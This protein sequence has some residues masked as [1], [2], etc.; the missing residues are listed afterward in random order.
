VTPL[1]GLSRGVV[2]YGLPQWRNNSSSSLS[3]VVLTPQSIISRLFYYRYSSH[4][5]IVHY[6]ETEFLFYTKLST[7]RGKGVLK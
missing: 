3:D 4:G 7:F 1:F 6:F 5:Y 2:D